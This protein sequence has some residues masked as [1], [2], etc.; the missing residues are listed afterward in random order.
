MASKLK[1]MIVLSEEM[2]ENI[3]SS[4]LKDANLELRNL[5]QNLEDEKHTLNSDLKK[6]RT[7]ND[8]MKEQ[9]SQ[10]AQQVQ[11]L[12]KQLAE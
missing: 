10:F 1:E 11:R 9:N 12:K 8:Q 3:R 2:S 4:Q 6:I 5:I 7:Q